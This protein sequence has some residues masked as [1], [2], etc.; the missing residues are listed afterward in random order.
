MRSYLVFLSRNKLYT[1]VSVFGFSVA[2]LFIVV[3]SLHVKQELSADRFH[4]DGERIFLFSLNKNI[5]YQNAL[6]PHISGLLP[7]V[8]DYCRVFVE[9]GIS[10]GTHGEKKTGA[11]G[12]YADSLFF[13]FFT[14]P[15]EVGDPDR[16]LVAENSVVLSRSFSNKLFGTRNPVGS[17][18]EIE[19]RPFLV[20]GIFTDL[21]GNTHFTPAD[22]IAPIR[23]MRH[24]WDGSGY[25]ILTTWDISTSRLYFRSRPGDRYQTPPGGRPATDRRTIIR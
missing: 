11:T 14:F 3:L 12:M 9:D 4:R 10:V 5:H 22:Y 6:A 21:P 24:F 13:T 7:E 23:A 17:P 20:T 2:L 15:L 16:V 8:A 19:G 25:D 1:A 18:I